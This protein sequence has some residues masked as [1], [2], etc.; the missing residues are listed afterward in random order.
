MSVP[1]TSELTNL[2]STLNSILEINAIHSKTTEATTY[3]PSDKIKNVLQPTNTIGPLLLVQEVP[4]EAPL[5]RTHD[6]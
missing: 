6:Q 5:L 4:N 1:T 2:S 3:S